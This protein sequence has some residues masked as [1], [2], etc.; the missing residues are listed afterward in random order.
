MAPSFPTIS[1]QDVYLIS[2]LNM[3]R[4]K[5][6]GA[7]FKVKGTTHMNFQNL[8]ISFFQITINKYITIC[9]LIYFRTTRY[10][11]FFYP[12]CNCSI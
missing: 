8:V 6:G 10:F 1:A 5:E 7:Y 3:Q 4:L 9:S 12:L 11:Q 2:K